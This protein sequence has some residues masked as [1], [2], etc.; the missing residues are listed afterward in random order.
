[1]SPNRTL[2]RFWIT[3]GLAVNRSEQVNESIG[4]NA[5]SEVLHLMISYREAL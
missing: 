5:L 3:S 1:L 4:D 2:P